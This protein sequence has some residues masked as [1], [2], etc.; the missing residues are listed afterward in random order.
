MPSAFAR[1]VPSCDGVC[2]TRG[3]EQ[4]R[5]V[6]AEL[7]GRAE[8]DAAWIGSFFAHPRHIPSPYPPSRLETHS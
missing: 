5:Q 1:F 2:G 6:G 8:E 7:W 3:T 4:E